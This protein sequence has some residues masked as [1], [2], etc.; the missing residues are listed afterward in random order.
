MT[1]LPEFACVRRVVA[2]GGL[3]SLLL[4][5]VGCLA[6]V[7]V[8]D[9][10]VE[11]VSDTSCSPEAL[12][13]VGTLDVAVAI[14]NS[15]STRDPSGADVDGDGLVG[16]VFESRFTDRDDS[17][18]K[19]EI[20]AVKQLITLADTADV[21]FSIISYSGP[22]SV[23]NLKQPARIVWNR[24]ARIHADLTQNVSRLNRVIDEIDE[25]GSKGTSNFAAGIRRATRTLIEG[26]DEKRASR[27]LVLFIS[28]SP[29]PVLRD[30]DRM[31]TQRDFRLEQ[32]ARQALDYQIVIN[33][34]GFSEE[35]GDWRL[36]TLG[37]IAGAT[38]GNYHVVKDP[39]QLYCHLAGSLVAA[40]SAQ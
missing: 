32:V 21:R 17:R 8:K 37:R 34:F 13:Q 1:R 15:F 26:I 2:A 22:S 30:I 33:T 9:N 31:D 27:R 4:P 7:V 38:G 40:S 20:A 6:P 18:L 19:A 23:P 5:M 28:D 24:D 16:D 3:V 36:K 12:S 35:S 29:M 10:V 25:N 14:D 39:M 11:V